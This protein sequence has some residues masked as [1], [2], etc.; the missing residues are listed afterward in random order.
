MTLT[1]DLVFSVVWLIIGTAAWL[2]ALNMGYR[3]FWRR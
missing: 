2:M 1:S 3:R